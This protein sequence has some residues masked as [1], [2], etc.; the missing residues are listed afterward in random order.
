MSLYTLKRGDTEPVQAI[1]K[2]NGTPVSL[3]GATLRFLMRPRPS[4]PGTPVAAVAD[5]LQTV[6]PISGRILNKGLVQWTPQTGDV[7]TPGVFD[8]EWEVSW[9]NGAV[10]TFP[11][12][13]YNVVVIEADLG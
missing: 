10:E 6:D 1:L 8:Q 5:I 3:Q 2:T 4:T 13:G 7:A 11:R 9:P 12:D